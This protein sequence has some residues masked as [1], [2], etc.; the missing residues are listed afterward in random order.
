MSRLLVVLALA[1]PVHADTLLVANRGGSTI[2]VIDPATMTLVTTIGVGSDP[3]EIAVSQDGRRAYVSNYGGSF[4]TTLSVIDIAARA[5]IRDVSVAPL[6]GPHG[7]VFRNGKVWFTAERSSAVGRYDPDADRVDWIGRVDP[8]AAHMLAVNLWGTTV[9]TANIT[10]GTASIIDVAGAE[11]TA[12]KSIAAVGASEGIALSPDETEVWIGSAQTGGIAVISLQSETVVHRIPGVFAY[13]LTFTHD[14]RY[15]LVPRGTSVVVYDAATRNE[16][17]SIPVGGTA[18]SVIVAPGSRIAYVAMNNPARVIKLDLE[19]GGI[20]G[21]V[22]VAP[23]P[24]GLAL[25][26][27]PGPWIRRRTA[28]T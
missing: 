9:Y 21:A 19:S 11:S 22:A 2:T 26:V 14:G 17:R 4:G 6:T 18:I 7:I 28:R 24:D 13:R 23:V 16:L 20:L 10:A 8:A 5:K 15:V 1:F 27:E 3:H 25:A 12:R